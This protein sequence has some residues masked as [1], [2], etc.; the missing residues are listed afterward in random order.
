[1]EKTELGALWEIVKMLADGQFH[2]G[3]ELGGLL[4]L[5][6]AAVWK[7]LQKLE[8]YGVFLS[9]VKGRGYCVEGGLDL[10]DHDV[11]EKGL[12]PSNLIS[13]N[14][15]PQ[16]DSTNSY[17]MRQSR[18][19]KQVCFAEFQS[20]G[21]GRRGRSWISPLAQNIYCSIGW[22][23]EGGVAALEGLSLAVGLAILRSIKKCGLVGASV[24]WPNDVL[25]SQKKL[26]GILIEMTGDP[27]GY[28]QVVIGVGLNVSMN[29]VQGLQID[30]PWVA[31]NSILKE[32]GMPVVSRNTVAITLINELTIVLQTYE[33]TGF[34]AY[35]AEWMESAAHKGQKVELRN[36]SSIVSGIFSGVTK[37]GALRLQT[38]VG[39]RIF[40]GGE[41]SLRAV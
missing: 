15:F 30:Q 36:G 7:H 38:D 18:S 2:S 4:G 24:K 6:R 11:I 33:K 39:E 37:T 27:A 32:E 35:Q 10:L 12:R 21:R 1:M 9:S 41:I 19:A 29:N 23:F 13:V 40:H 31:L 22:G 16:V 3:E 5:S 25:Y 17:L 20:A 28:C 26:A 34:A 8:Q 14:V